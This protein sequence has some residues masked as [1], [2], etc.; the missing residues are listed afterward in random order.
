MQHQFDV[1]LDH[2]YAQI[3]QQLPAQT[4]PGLSNDVPGTSSSLQRGKVLAH[5]YLASGVKPSTRNQ[6]VRVYSTWQ[7]FCAENNLP[8]FDAGHEAL[9]SCLSL[10]M[11]ESKSLSKVV[12]LS[13]AIANEHRIRMKK[14]PTVH[15]SISLLFRGFRLTHSKIREPMLPFSE[16]I[17]HKMIDRVYLPAHGRNGLTAGLV[18]WRTVWRVVMEFYTLGRFSDIIKLQRSDVIFESSPSAHLVITFQGG[19]NDLYSEGGQRIVAAFDPPTRYCPVEFTKSYFQYLGC[20]HTGFLVPSCDPF[21]KPAPAKPVPYNAALTDLRNLLDSLG[22]PS[23]DY[24]EHS[25]KRGGASTAADNGMNKD[26]LQR[27]GGWRSDVMPSKY[28]DL[29]TNSRL[30]LSKFLQNRL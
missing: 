24:G 16:D 10:V 6:Y 13:A 19:K 18:L 9:A 22:Y 26:D 29:S 7:N 23:K 30:K 1:N 25:G 4:S 21:F 14:S 20:Q 2:P 8:E 27:L 12:M 5:Q 11:D 15:E 28:T 3:A 17:L